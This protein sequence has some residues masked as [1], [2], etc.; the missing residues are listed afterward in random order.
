M[1]S[2]VKPIAGA[3]LGAG[4]GYLTGPVGGLSIGQTMFAGAA[5]GFSAGGQMAQADQQSAVLQQ[6]AQI[7][8]RDAIVQ[9]QN[10]TYNAQ[11]LEIEARQAEQ[12]ASYNAQVL[13]NEALATEQRSKFQ[14]DAARRDAARLRGEQSSLY[15][16]SGVQLTGSAIVVEADSEFMAEANEANIMSLG[17]MEAY[18]F[19]QQATMQNYQAGIEAGRYRSS[20]SETIRQGTIAGQ[21]LT[22]QAG[23]SQFQAGATQTAGLIDSGSTILGGA[24]QIGNL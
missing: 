18:K 3:A 16:F 10:A 9:Q 13:E 14:R 22:T 20:A 15:G 24:F 5:L 2:L 21:A 11:V 23:V 8:Q 19:R 6:N 7:A 12:V 17:E 1:G 4:V